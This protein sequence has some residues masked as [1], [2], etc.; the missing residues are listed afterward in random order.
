M[1]TEKRPSVEEILASQK[2]G[3][4]EKMLDSLRTVARR[5]YG[6]ADMAPESPA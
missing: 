2:Q 3:T 1:A 6:F 4:V 5:L